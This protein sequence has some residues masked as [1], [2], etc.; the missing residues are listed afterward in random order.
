MKASILVILCVVI[1]VVISGNIGPN[2][3]DI[4]IAKR[5]ITVTNEAGGY[6]CTI[7]RGDQLRIERIYSDSFQ[8]QSLE[9]RLCYATKAKNAFSRK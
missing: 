7:S 6:M 4:V 9:D 2:V 1:F 3:G 5:D 8:V